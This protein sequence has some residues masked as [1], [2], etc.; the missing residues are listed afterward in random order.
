MAKQNFLGLV[1]IKGTWAQ[2]EPHRVNG[3]LVFAEISADPSKGKYIWA[4]GLEYKVADNTD[5]D[6][7]IKRVADVSQYAIET[8]THLDDLSTFIRAYAENVSTHVNEVST[9]LNEVSTRLDN[10]STH[11]NE[12]STRLSEVSSGIADLSTYV[13]TV[14][15]PSVN[16][17]ETWRAEHVDPSLN[18]IDA[19]VKDH[20][21]RIH[22][23]EDTNY[24]HTIEGDNYVSFDPSIDDVKATIKIGTIETATE[25]ASGLAT[26]HDVS[27]FVHQELG[28][29]S[30][31]LVFRGGVN[32]SSALPSSDQKIGDTYVAT[33]AMT[34]PKADAGDMFIWNGTGWVQI[35]RNL[36]GAVTTGDTLAAG[37]M[38]QGAG[39]QAVAT[40]TIS[41]DSLVDVSNNAVRTVVANSST[42]TYLAAE[43]SKNG[44][45]VD[46]SYGIIRHDISTATAAED[47][48]ATAKDV[49]DYVDA[50][51]AEVKVSA[52]LNSSTP[53]YVDASAVVDAAGRVISASVGI[54]VATL[55]DASNGGADFKALA[56]ARDVYEKLTEVEKTMATANTAMSTTIG[57]NSDYSVTWSTASGIAPDTSI[58]K[59]IEQV[60]QQAAQ[61]GVTSFGEKKGAISIDTTV[62]TDGSVNF[63]MDGSTLKG[64]VVGWSDLVTRVSNNESSIGDI[65]TRVNNV[66]TRV[67]EV[68][69]RLND[70]STYVHQTVDASIDALQAKDVEI[71]ASIDRLDASVSAL[72]S[73]TITGESEALTNPNDA[74]VNVAATTD[75]Q[76]NVTLDSSVQLANPV[77]FAEGETHATPTGLATDGWVK[78]FLAWETI[79]D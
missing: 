16:I 42:P 74:Y 73:R 60:A 43:Y 37:Y 33:G 28:D 3:K 65:S 55:V 39:N 53:N 7:L 51:A 6:E 41:L 71:D 69:T 62:N 79:G 78:D 32:D 27:V 44:T 13:Y 66:S 23:L 20:E 18:A 10:A 1:R 29:L 75:A 59:A 45:Q 11:I 77:E 19:S 52:T 38:V 64:T 54:K 68:S 9:R 48:V 72:E 58:V 61:S 35:E 57:L 8:S 14:V 49:K 46:V 25:D 56:D 70:L 12:V 30:N 21:N 22:V 26:A 67:N 50:K 17:L 4:N 40:S 63:A 5:L 24:V 2:Y 76:G 15:D 36:D 47:G 31:A 34:S